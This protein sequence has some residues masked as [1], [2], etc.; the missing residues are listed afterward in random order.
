VIAMSYLERA[1]IMTLAFIGTIILVTT[2]PI[3]TPFIIIIG[4]AFRRLLYPEDFD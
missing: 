3:M 2:Y 1:I 4:M